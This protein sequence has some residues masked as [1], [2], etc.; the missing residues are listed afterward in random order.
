[1]EGGK[2]NNLGEVSPQQQ[3]AW[4]HTLSRSLKKKSVCGSVTQQNTM[5][6]KSI[7]NRDVLVWKK[8]TAGLMMTV[9][10]GMRVLRDGFNG[11]GEGCVVV[12]QILTE[13]RHNNAGIVGSRTVINE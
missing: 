11:G 8:D 6:M 13:L 1:M 12:G 2:N 7:S 5:T 9:I 10:I 3:R 4:S